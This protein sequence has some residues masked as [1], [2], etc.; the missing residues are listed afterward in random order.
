M[1]QVVYHWSNKYR[2]QLMQYGDPESNNRGCIELLPEN[3]GM[4]ALSKTGAV[5]GNDAWRMEVSPG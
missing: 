2:I 1:V 5:V 4:Q 3:L